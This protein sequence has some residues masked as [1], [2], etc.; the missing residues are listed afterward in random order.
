MNDNVNSPN[1]YTAGGIETIDYIKAKQSPEQFYGYCTGNILKYVSRARF[2]NNLED[3]KKAKVYL[4]W[5]IE[6][7]EKQAEK[8]EAA[9]R[10]LFSKRKRVKRDGMINKTIH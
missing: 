2:K 4:D 5:L 6:N 1:H 8:L 9:K 10:S 7:E 3:L